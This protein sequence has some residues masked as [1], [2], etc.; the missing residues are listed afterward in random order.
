MLG[1]IDEPCDKISREKTKGFL[2]EPVG[3]RR[4]DVADSGG[5]GVHERQDKRSLVWPHQ[6]IKTSPKGRTNTENTASRDPVTITPL[7]PF[8]TADVYT[9]EAVDD[10]ATVE[11]RKT[12]LS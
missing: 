3:G 4:D 1:G 10:K 6:R 11:H 9:C 5:R 7:Y 8:D 12:S 2:L